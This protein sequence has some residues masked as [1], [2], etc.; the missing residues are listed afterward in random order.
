MD[1][2]SATASAAASSV[3]TRVSSIAQ[4]GAVGVFVVLTLL[5]IVVV[6]AYLVWRLNS[7]T[8]TSV[9]ILKDPRKLTG[10]PLVVSSGKLPAMSVGQ[11]Y[12]YSFWVYLTDFQP[13]LDLG[14]LILWRQKSTSG[15][16]ATV[17]GTNPVVFMDPSVNQMY[18]CVNTTRQPAQAPTKLTDLLR[19]DGTGANSNWSYLSAVVEY[20][21]LQRWVNYTFTVQDS[22]LTVYQD[23]TLYTVASLYDMVDPENNVPRPM[24]GSSTGNVVVGSSST[25]SISSGAA[26]FAARVSFFNYALNSQQV[27]AI[28]KQG[29]SSNSVLQSLGMADYGVRSPI[30]RIDDTVDTDVT[31]QI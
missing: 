29:P 28:Y 14:K 15:G 20:V 7:S 26:G 12:S 31:K 6:V 11:P 30:Y 18:I 16:S 2:V 4:Y 3:G 27:L 25:G 9:R 5:L 10:T 24:F 22:L 21:P 23:G 1:R 17:D 19:K 13:S 8:F